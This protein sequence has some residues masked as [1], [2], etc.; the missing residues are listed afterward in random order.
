LPRI[1]ERQDIFDLLVNSLTPSYYGHMCIKK[2]VILLMLSGAKNL[3]NGTN[4]R[5]RGSSVVA[6]TAE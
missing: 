3:M 4:L 6:L 5:G 1:A 2:L